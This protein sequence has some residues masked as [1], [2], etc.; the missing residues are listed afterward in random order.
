MKLIEKNVS[1]LDCCF[2]KLLGELWQCV[3]HCW[4]LIL[5][6]ESDRLATRLQPLLVSSVVK[7]K[8]RI[9]MQRTARQVLDLT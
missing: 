1:D 4:E 8:V 6:R 2:V 9:G 7:V 5:W 3:L